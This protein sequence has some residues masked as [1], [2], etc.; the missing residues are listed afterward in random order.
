MSYR[1]RLINPFLAELEQ[2]DTAATQAAAGYDPVMKTV[3]TNYTG[4]VREKA[5]RYKEPI[6]LRAQVEMQTHRTQQQ[7]PAGNAPASRYQLVLHFRDLEAAS[8]LDPNGEPLLRVNDRL[9]GIYTLDSATL[10][11]VFDP[12]LFAV[13]V[14]T[15]GFGIGR[16]RNLCIFTFED[17]AQAVR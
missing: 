5:V 8:L 12:P 4:G 15:T 6:R 2:I 3:K 7:A 14:E 10:V 9:R 13:A 11:Q 1:G 16:R 17:R